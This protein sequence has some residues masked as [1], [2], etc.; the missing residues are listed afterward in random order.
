MVNKMTINNY[1][2]ITALFLT[3]LCYSL[4]LVF[5]FIG[6]GMLITRQELWILSFLF[7]S[8]SFIVGSALQTSVEMDLGAFKAFNN[9]LNTRK[10]KKKKNQ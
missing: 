3:L 9:K 6:F 5:V 8:F 7:A 1:M 4:F 10:K 2:T